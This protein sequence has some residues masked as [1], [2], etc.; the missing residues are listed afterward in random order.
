MTLTGL[1]GLV[2]PGTAP[3]VL[4]APGMVLLSEILWN[5]LVARIFSL[6]ASRAGDLRLKTTPDR[7]FGGLLAVL[8]LKLAAT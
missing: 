6:E 2:L 7:T 4:G 3:P 1:V 5:V 8:G